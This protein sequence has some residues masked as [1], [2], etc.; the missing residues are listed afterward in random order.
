MANVKYFGTCNGTTVE[1]LNPGYAD[2]K[3]DFER[4]IGRPMVA[5][6]KLVRDCQLFALGTCPT[7]G[8]KHVA[9][10]VIRYGSQPKLHNCSDR[11]MSAK[12]HDCECLCGGANHGKAA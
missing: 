4:M 9:E 10:R 3:R 1:L 7:C 6:E 12:G 8:A 5:G 11:C 2:R